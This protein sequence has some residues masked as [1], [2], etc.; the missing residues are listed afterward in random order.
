MFCVED[1][2]DLDGTRNKLPPET[3]ETYQHCSPPHEIVP[4]EIYDSGACLAE[5]A[6]L[7]QQFRNQTAYILET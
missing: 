4:R 7:L 3:N 1:G 5:C 6:A 2:I